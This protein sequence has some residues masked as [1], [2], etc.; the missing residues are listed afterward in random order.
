VPM[1]HLNSLHGA[2]AAIKHTTPLYMNISA[3]GVGW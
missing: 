1:E 2:L 3:H